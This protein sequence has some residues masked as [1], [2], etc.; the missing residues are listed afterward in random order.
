MRRLGFVSAALVG[1][2][3]LAVVQLIDVWRLSPL[4]AGAVVS[5]IPLATLV[6]APV[7]ARAGL[8]AVA[9]G[10]ALLAG[11]LA[12]M[13]LL[14]ASSIAWIVAAL[15][16]AGVGF[17]LA[18]PAL[19]RATPGATAVWI[20]HAGLVVGLI[21]ITPLLTDDLVAAGKQAELRGIST[22]LD[23]PVSAKSKLRLAIDLA[24]VLARPA[25]KELPDFTKAVAPEHDPA[26]T[27]MGRRLDGVVKATGTRGFRGSF[28][29]AALFAVV[30]AALTM[31]RLRAQAAAVLVGVAL[32]AAELASGALAYGTRPKLLPP[33][34]DRQEGVALQALDFLACRLHKSREQFVADAAGAGVDA[35]DFVKQVERLAAL[36]TR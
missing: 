2:L 5:V 14:P 32:L 30:A 33:C 15:A 4:R 12:G 10:C 20:R 24:P 29:V 27:A 9:P 13:A 19:T 28:L 6:V 1:L 34:A 8:A 16:I 7:A 17:G 23:A 35:V 18:L 36:L 26:L 11:G 25:R 21:A 3:F 31:R 22:V